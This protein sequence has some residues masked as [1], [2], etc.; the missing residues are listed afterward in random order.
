MKTYFFTCLV[1][2]LYASYVTAQTDVQFDLTNELTKDEMTKVNAREFV[3]KT[4]EIEGLAWPEVTF[5]TT[6]DATPLESVAVFAA[7]DIQK[8]YVPGVIKSTPTKHISSTDV[9]TAYEMHMPFPMSNAKYLHG[10]KIFRHKN[11]YEVQ[12]YMVESTSAE[13][14]KGSAYYTSFN[15]KTLFRY[16]SLVVPKSIFGSF[17]KKVMMK[18]VEKSLVAIRNFTEKNKQENPA[19]VSKYSEFITRALSGEFVYQTIIDKK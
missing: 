18:D 15:G 16:R 14:V 2:L 1:T 9:Y 17:V 8:D 12:W 3:I 11:D 10:G 6:I 5:Y 7:Y 4:R 13:D 19:L